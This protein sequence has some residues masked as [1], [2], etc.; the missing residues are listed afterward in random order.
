MKKAKTKTKTES[1]VIQNIKEH[2]KPTKM[3]YSLKMKVRTRIGWS[4]KCLSMSFA[5]LKPWF[6]PSQHIDTWQVIKGII[7]ETLKETNNNWRMLTTRKCHLRYCCWVEAK[8]TRRLNW[9]MR[10]RFWRINLKLVK[11]FGMH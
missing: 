9:P 4:I 2:L 1:T 3:S 5:K 10:L 7:K 11:S 8:M 6:K